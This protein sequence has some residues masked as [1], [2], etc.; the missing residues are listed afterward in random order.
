MNQQHSE[1]AHPRW[2]TLSAMLSVGVLVGLSAMAQAQ[3][4]VIT[5]VS[6]FEYNA[7][8][9]LV[10]E[11]MEPDLPQ[12]CLSTTYSYDDY[13]NKQTVSTAACAGAAGSTLA[14]ASTARTATTVFAAQTVTI[15][16]ANYSSPAGAFATNS[17]NALGQSEAKEYDPRFGTLTKLVGPNGGTTTW[18]YD[19][20]G[21]KTEERRADGTYTR[22]EYQFCGAAQSDG[23]AAPCAANDNL[24]GHSLVWYAMEASYASNG[25]LLAPKKFQ[26]HDTLERV[27]RI[28]TQDFHGQ[29]VVQDTHYNNIGQILQKS[30]LYRLSSGAPAW[31]R[32]QYDAMSRPVREEVPDPDAAGG[33]D[34]TTF[35]Y[36]GLVTTVTNAAGQTKTTHKSAAGRIAKVVDHLGG[37]I[38]YSY[39][40]LGQLV[41]TNAAGSITKLGYTQRGH[42]AWMEDPAM[43][44]WDYAYNAF[45]ELVSQT[46]SLSQSS[47]LAYDVLGRM[48]QRTEPD[49]ISNWHYDKKADGMSCGAGI[50]KLCEARASN[51]YQRVHS[52]DAIGRPI[53]TGTKLDSSSTLAQMSQT[54]DTV[55]GRIRTKTWPTGYSAAYTYTAGGYVSKVTGGGVAG[56]EQTVT[57]EVLGM[58]AQGAITQ[59]RQGNNITTVKNVDEVNGKLR[60]VQ[61]TLAGQ[62]TG[63]VF[64]HS[65]SYD[66][67]GNLKTRSDANTGVNESYQYDALNR[68]SLYTALGGGLPGTQGTQVLYDAAGN[69]KYRSDVG[70]YHYDA[71]RPNRLTNITLAQESGWSATG[72]VTYGNTGTRRLIYAFD[73]Y[74]SGSKTV[75]GTAVGNGNLWYTV[76][77]DDATGRHTVR[78]ETYTSFNMPKEILFGN[79]VNPAD[80]TAAVA[81]RTLTFV[82]GPEHQRVRQDVTL[83]SNAPSHMEAGTT[84]Y[85][86]GA[87]SQ[88]LAYEKEVK[89]NGTTEHKHY[90]SAGGITF[91]L[92]VKREG[93]LNGKS[94]T[95]ISYFH[96]DHLGSIAAV[97]NEAGAVVERMAYDPWGKRRFPDGN[98]DKLDALYGVTTDR[99][100]TMH[101][102]LDEMGIIH[103]NGRVFDPLAGRFMSSDPFIPNPGNLQAYNRY[104]Y[105]YNNPLLFTDPDGF[106]PFW[107]KKWFRQVASIAVAVYLG[108]AGG[109]ALFTSGTAGAA[110]ANAA[111]AGAV[112]GAVSTGTVRGAVQGAVVGALMYGVGSVAP[113]GMENVI[114]HAA[115]GC[116]SSVAS[117]GK[118]GSGAAAG[119]VG[120]LFSQYGPRFDNIV[121]DTAVHAVAGGVASVAGGG[122]FAN[123]AQTGAFGYLFNQLAHPLSAPGSLARGGGALRGGVLGAVLSIPN[124]SGLEYT[125]ATYTRVNPDT[126]DVYSGRTGGYADPET[127]VLQ[128]GLQQG[129]LNA[130]GFGPPRL[131]QW[132]NDYGAIR[133]REQMLID[134]YGG[135][136][137][138]G[139]SARNMINGVSDFNPNR[140]FYMDAAR[141]SFGPL[142]DNSPPRTR[143]G[144]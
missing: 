140:P 126:G 44:R 60:S 63:N 48:T 62:A 135:A 64:N 52:Y 15:A 7:E 37:E 68:L 30:N 21:R 10:K 42:K 56:H 57:F 40:A 12:D 110:I 9:L 115:V 141:R 74:R 76:S 123:G 22:W 80:P 102:H 88:G 95:S 51:G 38:V 92:Y 24:G 129:H 4:S 78:W 86:N 127:L 13:G 89:A 124:D 118:C 6:S 41:Q 132:T 3:T 23:S 67:L 20:F 114:G 84:W 142:P 96:H 27:V 19:G 71:A 11:V 117:G 130:E 14:S 108:P 81:D 85:Y 35:A 45:G 2:R 103:M 25:T 69:I 61:A 72:A 133:G 82:Y 101:E 139:G 1:R 47:T 136:R 90:V 98:G 107:K 65:Y 79:L 58:N 5:R 70:Y 33:T 99:G 116:V 143:L 49:L 55:T 26:I 34:V 100:Y 83:S 94:V 131:D 97:S 144:N 121:A 31:T 66:A 8:G 112:S 32:F 73:D 93:N 128:R 18:A 77:Q 54:Y 39:D 87:D 50:G 104:A 53:V 137:S 113:Q 46:D 75:N 91:A 43:G 17:T 28:Q 106:K 122:K 111:V 36:S 29:V 120:S 59:Y 16:G 105:V 125:Y 138:V 134:Y 109:G 119:A